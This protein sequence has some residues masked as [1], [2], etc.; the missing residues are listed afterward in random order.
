MNNKDSILRRYLLIVAILIVVGIVIIIKASTVM[1][2]ER[3]YW[4]Q[5]A[6]KY[7]KDSV[8][9]KAARGNIFSADDK[10]LAS[11]IPEYNLIIDLNANPKQKALLEENMDAITK[12]LHKIFPDKSAS[13]FRAQFKTG[14]KKKSRGYSIYPKRISYMQLQRVKELPVLNLHSNTSGLIPKMNNNRNKP[15]KSLASRTIGEVYYDKDMGAKNGIEQYFD[16]ELRGVDGYGH[17]QR[18]RNAYITIVDTPPIDGDDVI[19]TLNID[20]QDIS[21]KALVDKLVETKAVKGMVVLMEVAT[22]DI[23]AIVNMTRDSSGRYSEQLNN[24]IADLY[25]QGSTVKPASILIALDDKKTT[26]TTT[27]DLGN[28]IYDIYDR[29]I[30]DFNYRSG[31]FKEARVKT[32]EEIIMYSSNIGVGRTIEEGYKGNKQRFVDRFRELLGM[33]LDLPIVGAAKPIIKNASNKF[34]S[35]TSLAWMS[36][37]YE[38][39]I[40]AINVVTFYNA[41]ANDG[42][43]MSPRLVK[44]IN[45]GQSVI[46]EFSPKVINSQI[47]S[48]NSIKEVQKMLELVVSDGLGKN[49]KSEQFLVAGKTGT[50]QVSKGKDGYKGANSEHLLSFA[51]YFPADKP[52]YTCLVSIVSSKGGGGGRESALVFKE[53][54]ERVYAMKIKSR[55]E[56]E[57][58]TTS[59]KEAM[60]DIKR[61]LYESTVNVMKELDID[62]SNQ[63]SKGSK[64]IEA[65]LADNKAYELSEIKTQENLIPT[66]YGMGAKDAVHKL[67][68]LGL[69]VNIT[70]KG[71]VYRQSIQAGQVLRPGTTIRLELR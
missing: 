59:G 68:S 19:T 51:G 35:N 71:K 44:S 61:G 33:E 21:E 54:A 22:G 53:I 27:I 20:M 56:L 45:R 7:V 38:T 64:Y 1:Y 62:F 2:L 8:V 11:S 60:P 17:R 48:K 67:E 32:I 5:I 46:K 66:V 40:P 69:N 15:F 50:A 70:G 26:P 30:K 39:S 13:Y 28:G 58:E 16:K 31:G 37:G 36:F 12:G 42:K 3:D 65:K 34:F 9:I 41:L 43:M 49:A 52:E 4:S 63:D 55:Y 57:I 14:L 29:Q 6:R 10:L 23:K 24:V 47:A 25:E 18:V